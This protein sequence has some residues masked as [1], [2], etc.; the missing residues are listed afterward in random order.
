MARQ[1]LA[2]C[3]RSCTWF[4]YLSSSP[5][6]RGIV[7]T[8]PYDFAY[9]LP[10]SIYYKYLP[11]TL[12][13]NQF[14]TPHCVELTS[15]EDL[16]HITCLHY[17]LRLTCLVF[18]PSL[19]ILPGPSLLPLK[20]PGSIVTKVCVFRITQCQLRT[21]HPR[22]ATSPVARLRSNFAH[23]HIHIL[24]PTSL[25]TKGSSIHRRVSSKPTCV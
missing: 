5:P 16:T 22:F 2:V 23:L 8:L 24:H 25:L 11:L 3:E 12:Q 19:S 20:S 9:G 21:S 17:H 18:A 14:Q 4:H 7:H 10:T 6:W 1:N 15:Q 13:Y